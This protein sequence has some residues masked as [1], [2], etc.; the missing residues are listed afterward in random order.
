MRP[1]VYGA[2]TFAVLVTMGLLV[3]PG[4]AHASHVNLKFVT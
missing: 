4:P 2:P 1:H 3:A